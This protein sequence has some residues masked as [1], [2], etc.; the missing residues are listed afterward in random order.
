LDAAGALARKREVEA[1]LPATRD[2]RR[3]AERKRLVAEDE[4]LSRRLREIK[5][6]TKRMNARRNFAGVGSPLH[7]AILARFDAATVAELEADA[8]VRLAQRERRSAER[9]AAKEMAKT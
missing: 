8:M 1:M 4:A 6:E 3:A 2:P 9:K 5:E 7:E